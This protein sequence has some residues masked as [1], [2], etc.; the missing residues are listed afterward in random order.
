MIFALATSSVAKE[1]SI[2][3]FGFGPNHNNGNNELNYDDSIETNL[4]G[5]LAMSN[6]QNDE[7]KMN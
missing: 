7:Q 5:R 6:K 1:A 3:T 2:G 4:I